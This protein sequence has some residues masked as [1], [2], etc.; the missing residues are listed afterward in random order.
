MLPHSHPRYVAKPGQK[1]KKKKKKKKKEKKEDQT[2]CVVLPQPW[3][4]WRRS[5]FVFFVGHACIVSG[6]TSS[7]CFTCC[8]FVLLLSLFGLHARMRAQRAFLLA[9]Q[10]CGLLTKRKSIDLPC[11]IE[12]LFCSCLCVLS[13]RVCVYVC[14]CVC[15]YVCVRARVTLPRT[16]RCL[17]IKS[18]QTVNMPHE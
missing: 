12:S 14:V 11:S 9:S 1:K 8:G 6:L 17:P 16:L 15:V 7:F 10:Q 4:L 5:C 3:F 13:V 2:C 18:N